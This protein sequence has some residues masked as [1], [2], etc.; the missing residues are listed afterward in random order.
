MGVLWKCA[1][2]PPQ[3]IVIIVKKIMRLASWERWIHFQTWDEPPLDGHEKMGKM[4]WPVD[5][6]SSGV[7]LPVFLAWDC[8]QKLGLQPA[9]YWLWTLLSL[10]PSG[11]TTIGPMMSSP[12]S[13]KWKPKMTMFLKDLVFHPPHFC[14]F[15]VNFERESRRWSITVPV[16]SCFHFGG[17]LGENPKTINWRL[18]FIP[19]KLYIPILS[20]KKHHILELYQYTGINPTWRQAKNHT[21]W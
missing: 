5:G 16:I 7:H 1:M 3:T 18:Y 17:I 4:M 21:L 19:E 12:W 15:Q 6:Q 9:R 20:F 14:G 13:F 11:F 10:Y 2:N 8:C